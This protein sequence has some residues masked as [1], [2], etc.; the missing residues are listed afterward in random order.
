MNISTFS[1]PN[2]SICFLGK[3]A[4]AIPDLVLGVLD[5]GATQRAHEENMISTMRLI[6]RADRVEGGVQAARNRRQKTGLFHPKTKDQNHVV[7]SRVVLRQDIRE[8]TV[9]TEAVHQMIKC[10]FRMCM[11]TFL[12][13]FIVHLYSILACEL[14]CLQAP[15]MF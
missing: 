3:E 1:Y 13:H 4:A 14:H 6:R 15:F 12:Y 8:L 10:T 9:V 11:V 2:D 7:R 5:E